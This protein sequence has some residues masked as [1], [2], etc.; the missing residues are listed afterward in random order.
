MELSGFRK[1]SI[2][3]LEKEITIFL[4]LKDEFT[5]LDFGTK[6]NNFFIN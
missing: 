5:Q 4:E 1:L 6:D 2:E 3:S